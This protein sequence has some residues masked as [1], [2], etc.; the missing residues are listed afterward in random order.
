MPKI[1][2]NNTYNIRIYTNV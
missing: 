2:Q 1:T